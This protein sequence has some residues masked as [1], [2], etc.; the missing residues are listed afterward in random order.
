MAVDDR[1]GESWTLPEGL[2]KRWLLVTQY[3][4]PE[5]G[6]AQIRLSTLVK[7]LRE[8]GLEVEVFTAMPNYPTGEI[9]EKYRG[10]LRAGLTHTNAMYAAMLESLDQV[11][12]RICQKLEELQLSNRT[13]LI[14]TSDNGGHLPTT[15]NVPLRVGKASCYEG[16]TRVPLIVSWPRV[17]RAGSDC[18]VPVI[19]PDLYPTVLEMAALKDAAG[20]QPD[21]VSFVP[22]LRESGAIDRDALY[23]HYPHYQLYQQGG[24]T[25]YG[26]I[27]SGDW[28]LIEFFDDQRIELYN[29]KEDI[30]ERHNLATE[31]P[32]KAAQLLARLH[33]WRRDVGAQMPSPNPAYD[34]SQP[35][36]VPAAKAKKKA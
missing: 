14:F 8:Q 20:H 26:A 29:L 18:D 4:L 10:K 19:S 5:P 13:I 7:I 21:G 35:E 34:P 23:W 30:G 17:T 15:S 11:V 2:P 24:T 3:Y 22:L 28:K 6:A 12:G 27:R 9:A 16:G 31:I 33:Q 36:H 1:A 25:P 32:A